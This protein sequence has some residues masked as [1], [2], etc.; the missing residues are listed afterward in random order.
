MSW[1]WQGQGEG[2]KH[3]M[4]P[5]EAHGHSAMMVSLDDNPRAWQAVMEMSDSHS[6]CLFG[7]SHALFWASRVQGALGGVCMPRPEPCAC[8]QR[9]EPMPKSM[10]A[11][12]CEQLME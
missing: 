10:P 7:D 12:T 5:C 1:E 3:E 4:H 8:M 2:T 6:S 11:R 9:A